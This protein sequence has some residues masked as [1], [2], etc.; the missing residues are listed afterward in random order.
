MMAPFFMAMTSTS[1]GVIHIFLDV[2]VFG[3]KQACAACEEGVHVLL[4]GRQCPLC[5]E[6]TGV[7]HANWEKL[8]GGVA[9]TYQ[10]MCLNRGRGCNTK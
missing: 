2:C 9:V 4:R 6:E 5:E 8:R 1:F 3:S 7:P 10:S